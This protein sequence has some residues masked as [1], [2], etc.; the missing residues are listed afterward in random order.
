[1]LLN[2]NEQM[3]NDFSHLFFS[4]YEHVNSGNHSKAKEI[5]TKQDSLLKQLKVNGYDVGALL[6]DLK[7][8]KIF[9]TK[10]ETVFVFSDGGVRNNHDPNLKPLSASAFTIYGDK[11]I[12]KHGGEFI[13]DRITLPNGGNIEVNSTLAEYN[14]ILRALQF[15]EKYQV[16]ADKI[17]FL[18]DCDSIV[19]HLKN[20]P[21]QHIYQDYVQELQ[22]RLTSFS[23]AELKHIPRELNKVTDALVNQ[24]MDI[25]ERGEK[26]CH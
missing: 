24:L 13:G 22:E 16:K 12:I 23:N 14:G 21:N 7:T 4:F 10:Y 6:E 3:A 5:S 25:H 26:V 18:T 17:V 2:I 20:L 19:K 9:Q 8:R 1:M 15:V 11:K